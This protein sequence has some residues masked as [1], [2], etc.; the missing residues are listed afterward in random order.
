MKVLIV[1]PTYNEKDNIKRLIPMIKKQ[2]PKADVLVVDDRSPDGTG[3]AVRVL[4]RSIK[5]IKLI[6]RK[7]KLGLGTAYVEGFKYALEHKYEYIFEM[8][9]DFSHDP[10]YLPEI[11][12]GMKTYDLVIGSRYVNG[13]SV[14]NWPI[15]R[16]ILSKFANFYAR[17][18]TGLPLTDLT[19]GF[20]CYKSTVLKSI[21]LDKIHSDGYAFQ[22]EMHYKAW[23][24]GFKIKE[25]PIIF[26]DR[27]AGSSK[28]SRKVISEAAWIVWKLK[29]GL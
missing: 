9:A 6:E 25:T 8:D 1:I 27:H 23:K 5:G 3:A 12:K 26:V 29:L 15:R 2:L 21:A 4:A 20:K 16:L 17:T 24:K 28:M 13:I 10:K 18:I 19:S 14:V 7:G 22:I 11:M